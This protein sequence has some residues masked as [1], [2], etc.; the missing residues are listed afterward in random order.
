MVIPV[1]LL[2]SCG[3][4]I[5]KIAPLDILVTWTSTAGRMALPDLRFPASVAAFA[6]TMLQEEAFKEGTLHSRHPLYAPSH[7]RALLTIV[8]ADTLR[9]RLSRSTIGRGDG[10]TG[11]GYYIIALTF[12]GYGA[13]STKW[14]SKR[15]EIMP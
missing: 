4:L 8:Q 9:N 15:I 12:A 5:L 6:L 1:V 7:C 13:N 10:A 2:D 11:G 3:L 14:S